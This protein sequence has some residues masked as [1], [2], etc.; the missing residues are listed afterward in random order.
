MAENPAARIWAALMTILAL[1][2]M[3]WLEMPA[4]QRALT[5]RAARNQLRRLAAAAA[6]QSGHRAMGRELAGTPQE[7]AGYDLT[8]H[9]S[10]LRDRL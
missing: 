3:A 10:Q 8:L 5:I 4:W 1:A 6:R 9:L 7:I 2:V